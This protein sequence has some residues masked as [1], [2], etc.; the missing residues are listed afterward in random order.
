[1]CSAIALIKRG[2]TLFPIRAHFSVNLPSSLNSSGKDDISLISLIVRCLTSYGWIK[3]VVLLS[4]CDFWIV[5]QG[6][7]GSRWIRPKC[8]LGSWPVSTRKD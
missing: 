1:M 6:L 3:P 8:F 2:G 4:G 7:S 5:G